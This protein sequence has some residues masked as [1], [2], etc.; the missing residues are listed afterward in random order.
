MKIVTSLLL[1]F[2]LLVLNEISAKGK[3]TVLELVIQLS[4]YIK[5]EQPNRII[6]VIPD[7]NT[8]A[9]FLKTYYY[10]QNKD[11][12]ILADNAKDKQKLYQDRVGKGIKEIEAKLK[13]FNMPKQDLVTKDIQFGIQEPKEGYKKSEG[14]FMLDRE[15]KSIKVTFEGLMI[16]KKWYLVDMGTVQN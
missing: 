4:E 14:S 10:N 5:K 2:S 6:K 15:G 9:K 1:I 7:I 11:A 3:K 13:E 12:I 8:T 16:N